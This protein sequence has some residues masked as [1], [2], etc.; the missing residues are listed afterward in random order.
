M[1]RR[2]TPMP[3]CLRHAV[4]P[5]AAL[6]AWVALCAGPMPEARAA[7]PGACTVNSA[8]LAFGDYDPNALSPTDAIAN[9]TV[10]CQTKRTP[11]SATLDRGAGT[12]AQR[13]MVQGGE[14]LGYNI[15]LNAA[16]SV[17]FGDGTGGSSGVSCISGGGGGC[18]SG[19]TPCRPLG[20]RPERWRRCRPRSV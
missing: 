12:F 4:R 13:Q 7:Q 15:Y 14:R 9:V 17:V 19:C 10:E 16:R 20:N 1:R 11:F 3:D 8:G 6:M 18:T 5:V 2:L